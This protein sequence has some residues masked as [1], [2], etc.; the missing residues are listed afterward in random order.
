MCSQVKC[1][2]GRSPEAGQGQVEARALPA[3]HGIRQMQ[4]ADRLLHLLSIPLPRLRPMPPLG[5]PDHDAA[6][7]VISLLLLQHVVRAWL[8]YMQHTQLESDCFF[9]LHDR[10]KADHYAVHCVISLLLLQH[11]LRAWFAY[12][13]HTHLESDCFFALHA[14]RTP[15]HYAVHCVVG[16]LLLQQVW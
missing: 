1:E 5:I 11:I 13:H 15:D 6:H 7:C 12:I 16:L 9:A 2:K 10:K 3:F 8:T 14:R 4:C